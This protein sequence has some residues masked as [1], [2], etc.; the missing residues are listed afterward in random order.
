MFPFV[1]KTP[2]IPQMI[3]ALHCSYLS[4]FRFFSE[5][6]WRNLVFQS[7]SWSQ[8]HEDLKKSFKISEVFVKISLHLFIIS[9]IFLLIDFF[10]KFSGFFFSSS[11]HFVYSL[12]WYLWFFQFFTFFGS[13]FLAFKF[14]FSSLSKF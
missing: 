13:S 10:L 12:I 2:H 6:V 14:A 11:N 7:L 3:M 9:R 4:M 8:V 5:C 1:V